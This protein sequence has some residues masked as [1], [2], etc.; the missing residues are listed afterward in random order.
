M[1]VFSCPPA[2]RWGRTGPSTG[3]SVPPHA[4]SGSRRQR[5][6]DACA[7]CPAR[8]PLPA[9]LPPAKAPPTR[10]RALALNLARAL[11]LAFA[12]ALALAVATP[13]LLQA[14]WPAEL[15]GRVVDGLTGAGIPGV[16]V[17]L[18]GSTTIALSDAS[19]AFHLRGLEPGTRSVLVRALGYLPAARPVELR[20]GEVTRLLLSLDPDPLLHSTVVV[21]GGR[22]PLLA[23]ATRLDRSEVVASGARDAADL[24]DRI[25]GAVVRSAGPGGPRTV[26]LRGGTPDGVLVL[27]DGV[28]MNDPLTGEADLSTIPASTLESVT[29]I[30]GGRSA[31]FGPRAES[32]VVLLESRTPGGADPE[33]TL[34]VGSLGERGVAGEVGHRGRLSLS[35]G[36]SG[37]VLDGRFPYELPDEAGGGSAMR[38]NGDLRQGSVRG[39]AGVPVG[40][41]AFLLR[42]GGEA[43]DRGL[44]GRGYAPADSARQRLRRAHGTASWRRSSERSQ[45]V[46]SLDGRSD[47][48]RYHDPAP[49]T[50]LPYDDRIRLSTLGGRAEV[51]RVSTLPAVPEVGVVLD[52]RRQRV[53]ATSL[54]QSPPTRLDLGAGVRARLRW[55]GTDLEGAI[56]LRGDRDPDDRSWIPSH[57]VSLSVPAGPLQFRAAHRSGFSP[58]GLADRYFR[59]GVGV[60]AN[61]D[62]RAQRVPGELELGLGF[63]RESPALVTDLHLTVYR[64]DVRGMITWLPDFRFVWSPRNVDV[65]RSGGEVA[66]S[67]LHPPSGLRLGG[68]YAHARVVYDRPGPRDSV[69]VAYRPR[70]TG[71]LEAGWEAG[72]WRLSTRALYTGTRFPVPA[73]LNALPPF[74]TAEASAARDWRLG[75]WR[76]RG[77]VGV[78]RLLDERDALI[79][80]VPEPGRTFRLGLRILP[81]SRSG[82]GPSLE[83]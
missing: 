79:F 4:R 18:D 62:L 24:M 41:G 30:P 61:P 28:P 80:A 58:P 39:A 48:L 82:R 33:V 15:S 71:G 57:E 21:D 47:G 8:G 10:R 27:L 65:K 35:L 68:H 52:A 25:P 11:A 53:E 49:P 26:S 2:F 7:G 22:A 77:T 78:Q 76:G 46:V 5:P 73:P 12:L 51:T 9:P 74:W 66:L 43:L 75:G 3:A 17:E 72:G 37:R 69:Q 67:V 42:L 60:A 6:V 70:H 32:G 55:P 19:G 59:E 63:R 40:G 50:G 83:P 38:E 1:R 64:G 13:S 20:N 56:V 31:R 29:V 45:V 16:R 23:G 34:E 54:G 81:P 36:G 14:Q 44:P